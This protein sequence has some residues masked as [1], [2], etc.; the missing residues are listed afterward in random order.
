MTSDNSS[1]S[2]EPVSA[3]K[4]ELDNA[5]VRYE[6]VFVRREEMVVVLPGRGVER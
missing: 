2:S 6:N 3:I 1:A 4:R 5:S